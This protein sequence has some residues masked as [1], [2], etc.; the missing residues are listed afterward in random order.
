MPIVSPLP[1]TSARTAPQSESPIAPSPK[2][3]ARI[4]DGFPPDDALLSTQELSALFSKMGAPMSVAT[5]NTKRC[6]GD[7]PPFRTF[8]HIV[9][10]HWGEARD[11]RMNNGRRMRNTSEDPRTR[12]GRK[13]VNAHQVDIF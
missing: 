11:W 1:R 6:R 8:E 10:C 3:T 9:R 7:G 13:A 2:T 4:L 5:L 12:R